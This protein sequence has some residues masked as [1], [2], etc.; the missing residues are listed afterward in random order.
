MTYNSLVALKER[1]DLDKYT[2]NNL[3]LFAL[4]IGLS[5]ED[6]HSVATNSL[7]D[8]SDDKKCDLLYVDRDSGKAIIAQSYLATDTSKTEAPANKASDLNTAVSW[9][10]GKNFENL[11]EILRPAAQE[12]DSALSD[13][14]INTIEIWYVHNLPESQNVKR[15]LDI[16]EKTVDSLLKR[17]Y[18]E[19][20]VESVRGLEV[21]RNTLEDWF[22][23]IRIP[24]IVNDKLEI[25]VFGGFATSGDQWHAYTTSVSAKWF[26]SLYNKHG[27]KLFSVNVRGYLGSRKSD[28][29][30]NYN[31]KETAQH[32]PGCF[33]AYNNG[34]TALVNKWE[35]EKRDGIDILI[36][37]GISIV[38]GAQTTGAIGSINIDNLG[39]ANILVRFVKC[40]DRSVVEDIVRYNNMQNKVE[41]SDFR[42]ND[43]IQDRLRSEFL[44]IPDTLYTGGRRGGEEDKIKRPPN[45]IPFSTVAQCLAAF[46]QEPNIAYNEKAEIWDS[47]AIYSRYFNA[48]TTAK[49]ILFCYSLLKCIEQTKLELTNILESERTETQKAQITFF[50]K[51]GSTYILCAAIAKCCEIFL[52]MAI[53]DLFNLMFP[54][55]TNLNQAMKAWKPIVSVSLAFATYLNNSLNVNLKIMITIK[56]DTNQFRS[57]IDATKVSNASIYDAFKQAYK[58]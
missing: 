51:R 2:N 31:I 48:K 9:L 15:E 24:I 20:G 37:V 55:N 32:K 47:D 3:L 38:N 36:I 12:L 34:I 8:H 57:F 7:T 17:H 18:F 21:G 53:P 45:L 40:D 11:P 10:L 23:S 29:N 5:I 30:I 4:E 26:N 42:S 33:W 58:G 56:E 43:P 25:P 54:E 6:I 44:K 46:H 19:S 52:G 16:V 13:G 50:R 27:M 41:A 14:V 22:Q 39:D 28:K 35:I 1:T 49:H